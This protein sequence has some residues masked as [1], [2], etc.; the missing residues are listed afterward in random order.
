M[1]KRRNKVSVKV[2]GAK[3]ASVTAAGGTIADGVQS[4]ASFEGSSGDVDMDLKQLEGGTYVGAGDNVLRFS[5]Q[6]A[7]PLEE[8]TELISQNLTQQDDIEDMKELV[9]ELKSQA[10]KSPADRNVS[11]IKRLLNNINTY[12]G[13]ASL[14]TTQAEK[15]QDLHSTVERLLSGT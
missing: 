8:L 13:L 5:N 4:G 15:A 7:V 10:E 6:V 14:A 1:A 12:L 9:A 11:K 2:D 3:D